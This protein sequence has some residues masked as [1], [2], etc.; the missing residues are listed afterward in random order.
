MRTHTA[1]L[2][3]V[4]ALGAFAFLSHRALT[5]ANSLAPSPQEGGDSARRPWMNPALSPDQR[6]DMVLKQLTPDEKIALLHGNG[7]AHVSQWQMPLTPLANGGAGYVQGV[8]RLGIPGL[9]ITDA[10]YGVRSSGDNGRYSTA[11]PSNLG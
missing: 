8:A 4:L 10:A 7:M 5:S 3:A 11:L 1:F 6:A 2:T 9:A